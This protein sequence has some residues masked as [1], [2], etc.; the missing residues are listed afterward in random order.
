MKRFLSEQNDINFLELKYD[1]NDE[2]II[3][4]VEVYLE[5]IS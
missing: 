2:Q 3:E 1:L 4:I 5:Q